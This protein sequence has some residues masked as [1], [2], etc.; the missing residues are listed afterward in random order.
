MTLQEFVKRN[1]PTCFVKGRLADLQNHLAMSK[2]ST[3]FDEKKYGLLQADRCYYCIYGFI[4]AAFS[5]GRI[6]FE[7]YNSLLDELMDL[8][9]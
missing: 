8:F 9:G 3:N 2:L 7:E 1:D 5:Y 4:K 6:T